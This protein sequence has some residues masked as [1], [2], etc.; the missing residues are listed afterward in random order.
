MATNLFRRLIMMCK[1]DLTHKDW[2][3]LYLAAIGEKDKS[4]L[5]KRISDAQHAI[6]LREREIF[7]A[8]KA[9]EEKEALEDA[10]YALRALESAQG[11]S[12]VD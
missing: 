4:A 3:L 11:H 1:V 8:G 6:F 2:K 10:L 5:P 12:K 7:Y 9:L